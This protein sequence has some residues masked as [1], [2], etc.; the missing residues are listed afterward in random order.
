[1]RLL[2]LQEV[3]LRTGLSRPVIYRLVGENS[4]PQPKRPTKGRIAW[5]EADV[6]AWMEAL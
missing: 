4:F 5:L 3:V 2:R 6:D 1:M